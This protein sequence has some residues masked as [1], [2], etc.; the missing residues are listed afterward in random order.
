MNEK[1]KSSR[2]RLSRRDFLKTAAAGAAGAAVMGQAAMIVA[3]PVAQDGQKVE[4]WT[5]FGQGRMA[6]AMA[7]AVEQ[8]QMEND[9]YTVDHVIVPWGEIHDQVIASTA[10]GNPP[11]SYR[12]WAWI[13]PDDAAI[14]AL[15]PLT[16][17]VE[18]AGVDLTDFW[19]PTLNQMTYQDQIYA[20]SISTIVNPL[21]F[22]K[23]RMREVGI[24]VDDLPD[25]LEGWEALGD[26]MTEVADNGEIQKVGFIPLIPN[27]QEYHWLAA[28]GGEVWDAETQTA[29]INTPEMQEVFNWYKGYYDR[30]GV[31]NIEAYA[32]TYGGNGFGRNTPEGVYYTGLLAIWTIGSWLVNDMNEYGPD[33]DFGITK[34][35]SPA[36][37]E[38]GRP[39]QL[40]ANMYLV[41]QGAANVQG[42][43]DFAN[44]MSSSPWVAINKA[45][46]DSVTPSRRSL[47]ELPEVEEAAPWI[48][49]MRDEVLPFAL[50][51]PSMP[52]V[53][54]MNRTLA[55]A[56]EEVAF[57]NVDI[58]TALADAERRIQRE[59]D[60]KLAQ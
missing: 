1:N 28:F 36:S 14:G 60:N 13:V 25:D 47:A 22:N 12:G 43:F 46:V 51:V 41:P 52:A 53:N 38:N 24:D 16:E 39:G 33:V 57:G 34:V 29:S 19:E 48:P 31:E 7:G 5:G 45:V 44:F 4:V 10:A 2:Q 3:A 40:Q 9:Q 32:S 15:T 58:E 35:P 42:G 11:D 18:T 59:V 30:Y 50:A 26:M 20:M 17:M 8:F 56:R 55:E 23:D 21:F 49:L 27:A 37:A 54:F 6:D